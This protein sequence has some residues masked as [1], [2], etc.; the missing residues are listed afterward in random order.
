MFVFRGVKSHQ[1]VLLLEKHIPPLRR[2]P[3]H[4]V[5]LFKESG[6]GNL[7]SIKHTYH[8]QKKTNMAMKDTPFEDVFPI[9]HGDFLASHLGCQ[10][11]QGCNLDCS[12]VFCNFAACVW[13]CD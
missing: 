8:P 3:Q 9:E 5:K 10:I 2:T 1:S 4:Y 11:C 12:L 6:S 13:C 7:A